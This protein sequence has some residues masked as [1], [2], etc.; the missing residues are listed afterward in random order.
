MTFQSLLV[1]RRHLIENKLREYLDKYWI[2]EDPTLKQ[3]LKDFVLRGGKR[4]RPFL[5]IE[6]YR[7]VTGQEH[8]DIVTASLMVEFTEGSLLIH[9]D[10]IDRDTVRRGGPTLHK[11]MESLLGDTHVG[12]SSAIVGG[13]LLLIQSIKPL[14]DTSFSES[15]KL[16]ALECW[17][18]AVSQCYFGQ[19]YDITLMQKGQLDESDYFHMV[20]LKTVS[21]T[22]FAPIMIGAILAGADEHTK[23]C[24][25]EYAIYLGRAYQ[26]KDDLLG[27]WG[28]PNKTGKPVDSDIKEGKRTLLYIYAINHLSVGDREWFQHRWGNPN[29]TAADVAKVKQLLEDVGARKYTERRLAE[30]TSQ[31][32]SVIDKMPIMEESKTVFRELTEFIVTR[33]Y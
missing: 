8:D 28:N 14:L 15:T 30:L 33:S 12:V 21:Y 10:I 18:S 17:L 6:A 5:L 4:L 13:D 24:Y 32:L 22:T 26:V 3:S 27:I 20:D 19:I 29:L 25:K 16:H 11:V 9:D 1:K 7:G 23:S 2:G 31:A